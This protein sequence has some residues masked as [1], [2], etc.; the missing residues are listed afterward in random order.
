MIFS[1]P[2][3]TFQEMSAPIPDPT[4]FLSKETKAKQNKQN[5]IAAKTFNFKE[6]LPILLKST[7]DFFVLIVKFTVNSGNSADFMSF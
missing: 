5:K 4:L 7:Y 6:Y 2:D 3:P 1:D